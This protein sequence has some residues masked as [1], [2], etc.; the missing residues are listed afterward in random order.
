MR[1]ISFKRHRFQPDV[2][3]QAVCLYFRFTLIPRRI[4]QNG[5]VRLTRVGCACPRLHHAHQPSQARDSTKHGAQ[6][7]ALAFLYLLHLHHRTQ[8][9]RR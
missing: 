9:Q 2:I 8:Q 3:R 1:P 7:D 4:D 5:L 6:T